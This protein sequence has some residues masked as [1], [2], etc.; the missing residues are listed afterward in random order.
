[1]LPNALADPELSRQILMNPVAL[2]AMCF[3]ALV[4]AVMLLVLVGVVCE[5]VHLARL[6]VH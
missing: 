3:I 4:A 2:S 5:Y 1:M 6:P